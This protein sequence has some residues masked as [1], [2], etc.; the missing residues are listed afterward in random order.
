MHLKPKREERENLGRS[1]LKPSFE[2]L[3]FDCLGFQKS[4]ENILLS[5]TCVIIASKK[6]SN[7]SAEFILTRNNTS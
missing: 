1:F 6:D 4:R 5:A 7:F 3:F 2:G